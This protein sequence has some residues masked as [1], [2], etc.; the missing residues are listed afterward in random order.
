M[1]TIGAVVLILLLIFSI[2]C[3]IVDEPMAS[4]WGFMFSI[5]LGSVL[6]YTI[7]NN[8]DKSE[9]DNVLSGVI[10]DVV[11]Y[12]IDTNVVIND[13]DTLKTYT[14]TYFTE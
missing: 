11:D 3:L 2:V 1:I 6:I 7:N 9:D 8:K 4:A 14:I 12:Q 5:I 10:Y 13:T